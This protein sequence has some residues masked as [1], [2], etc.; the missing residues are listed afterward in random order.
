MTIRETINEINDELPKHTRLV[1]VSKFHPARALREAYEAGQRIFGESHAQE[2]VEK[3]ENLPKDIQWHFI[4]HL[5]RNKVKDIV[6]FVSMIHSVD[7]LRLMRKINKEAQK[8]ER[9]IPI[10]LQLHIADE[11]TKFG[12]SFE[13]VEALLDDGEWRQMGGIRISGLMGMAT[14]TDNEEQIRAEFR[15]LKQFF[16]K[17]KNNYFADE[18][19]F[20]EISMGMSGD[21]RIAA[22][23]GSTL[24]RI[25]TRIF[26]K[27]NYDQ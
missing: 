23:E 14:Q 13:E 1:A 24:V 15:S 5:Q 3:Y 25:G 12:F 19:D 4:G 11:N 26:G 22:E 17:I 16:D 20:K 27:R 10:L 7:S 6:P 21:Y 2:V 9:A 8:A 18:A